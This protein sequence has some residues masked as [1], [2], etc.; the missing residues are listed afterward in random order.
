MLNTDIKEMLIE[1]MVC[2]ESKELGNVKKLI[3]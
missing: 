3:Y 1:L 2:I